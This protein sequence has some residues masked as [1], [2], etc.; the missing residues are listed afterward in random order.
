MLPDEPRLL[1]ALDATW[2]AAATHRAG[3]FLI[4]EGKGGGKRVSAA[5]RD[6]GTAD[7]RPQDIDAAIA[8]MRALGQTPLFMLRTVDATLDAD[9]AA[10]GFAVVDP[11][12]LY[13]APLDLITGEVPRVTVFDLWEP[14]AISAE[15]W[16]EAGIGPARLAVMQR[17]A[18]PRT[19][20]LSRLG[21]MPAGTAFVACDGKVAMIHALEVRPEARRK[22]IAGQMM[23]HGAAWARRHGAAYLA[24]AVTQ[25]NAGANALYS[26]LG[27]KV[28]GQYHYRLAS[29]DPE[30]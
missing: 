19:A 25:A 12:N 29:K 16:A 3:G 9:L 20:L 15:I 26:S 11:V 5:T 27:M 2:P 14:L 23:R 22:G 21:Q 30:A 4:R 8:A 7:A 13:A 18:G 28:V 24:L 1:D 6:A 17:V 10:R